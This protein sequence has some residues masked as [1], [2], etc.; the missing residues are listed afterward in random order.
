M[1]LTIWETEQLKSIGQQLYKERKECKVSAQALAESI[2]VSRLTLHRL[3][4]GEPTVAIGIFFK[5]M[6]ALG[7]S[8]HMTRASKSN[9]STESFLSI[10]ARIQLSD[11]P[12]LRN[13]TWHVRGIS[14]LKPGEAFEIYESNQR[15]LASANLNEKEQNLIK[16]LR[17]AF[18]GTIQ[19]NV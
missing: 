17:L 13:L 3:E 1:K 9:T 11:Y 16:A 2:Q 7:S 5:V 18:E 4:K 8:C 19:N 15:H 12:E 14:F 6:G 10:P